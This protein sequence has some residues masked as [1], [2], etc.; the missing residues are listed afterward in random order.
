MQLI[1]PYYHSPYITSG[2]KKIGSFFVVVRSL[3]DLE[4]KVCTALIDDAYHIQKA[5]LLPVIYIILPI[6][7]L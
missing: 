2:S 6:V 5:V 3:L 1:T 7:G 4:K